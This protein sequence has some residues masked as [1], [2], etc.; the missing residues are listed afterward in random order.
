LTINALIVFVLTA[1]SAKLGVM[2]VANSLAKL[3]IVMMFT[4]FSILIVIAFLGL[5][6][7]TLLNIA[8][9]FSLANRSRRNALFL[10]SNHDLI[11][12]Q[13]YFRTLQ[14]R[15]W[16]QKKINQMLN[17]NNQQQILALSNSINK[18]LQV[19]KKNLPALTFKRLQIENR[20]HLNRLDIEALLHLQQKISS[21]I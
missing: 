19:L 2:V 12:R 15:Y 13:F 1:F 7:T 16:T 5:T 3:G 8:V 17:K 18:D 10:Q 9:Y 4:A 21:L 14:V 11:N 20:T 6:K